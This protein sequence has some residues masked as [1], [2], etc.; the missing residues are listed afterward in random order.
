MVRNLPLSPR[1]YRRSIRFAGSLK[2]RRIP[3]S[4]KRRSRP[5]GHGKIGKRTK[6]VAFSLLSEWA[7]GRAWPLWG[8][9]ITR[10]MFASIWA[11]PSPCDQSRPLDPRI[12]RTEAC[13]NNQTTTGS[14]SGFANR[15]SL[16]LDGVPPLAHHSHRATDGPVAT[17]G[18]FWQV[19]ARAYALPDIRLLSQ[20]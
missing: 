13:W 4:F 17:R 16:A 6:L 3:P 2:L 10:L 5:D 11:L 8:S 14:T 15:G 12:C 9:K 1:S 19:A 20:E 7:V 18:S